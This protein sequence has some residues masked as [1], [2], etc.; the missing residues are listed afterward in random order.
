MAKRT[1]Q[2]KQKLDKVSAAMRM[3]RVVSGTKAVTKAPAKT[4]PGRK[5]PA[6]S[7]ATST[8]KKAPAA[9]KATS[10]AKKAPAAS[11]AT[12]TAKKAPAASKATSTA[13][14]APAKKAPDKTTVNQTNL[15]PKTLGQVLDVAQSQP[16][17]IP[18]QN[19]KPLPLTDLQPEVFEALV[20]EYVT[21]HSR[22]V[23][24]YG[25]S[26]QA[27]Y[28]LDIVQWTDGERPTVFQVK[29]F[30]R[31]R[32]S[33]IRSAVETYASPSDGS[34]RQFNAARFVL[35]T[36]APYENDTK[37][38]NEYHALQEQYAGDL[39]LE[40]WGLEA[41][42]RKIGTY[43][44]LV[45][46][47]IGPEW[48]RAVCGFNPTPEQ[49]AG[50]P[51]LAFV[52]DPI[53]VLS[54]SSLVRSAVEAEDE[55]PAAAANSY[56]LV[57]DGLAARGFPGH[58]SSIREREAAA[59][60]AAGLDT[61]AFDVLYD[62]VIRKVRSG[63]LLMTPQLKALAEVS[64]TEV[65]EAKR[66]VLLQIANWP[67][68]GSKL[69]TTV[70]A[71]RTLAAAQDQTLPE[72]Y[73]YVIE[74]ALVDGL[75]DSEASQLLQE[76]INIADQ[77]PLAEP[78]MRARIDCC[79][80]DARLPIDAGVAAVNTMYET[81]TT[82]A[83]A[84]SYLQAGGFVK[85]RRAYAH[86]M[87]G[88]LAG[89]E[90][91]W[92]RAI[93]DSGE[94]GFYGDTR[95]ALRS[96][97]DV[98]FDHGLLSGP[99]QNIAAA[100]PNRQ[101]LLSIGW[102]PQIDALAAAHEAELPAAFSDARRW[103]WETRLAGSLQL[104]RT[105]LELLGDILAAAKAD[106]RAVAAYIA[107]GA[108]KKVKKFAEST[109]VLDIGYW[110]GTREPRRRAAIVE[111]IATQAQRYPDDLVPFAVEVLLCE[112]RQVWQERPIVGPRPALKAI[113]ALSEFGRR[114]PA[115]AVDDI[116]KIAEPTL[117]RDLVGSDE[118]S[119]LLVEAYIAV[120]TR[121]TD[122]A[123]ALGRMMKQDVVPPPD[124]WSYIDVI[125]ESAR[126][127]LAPLVE[128]SAETGHT[129]AI[130]VAAAWR[131]PIQVLQLQARRACAAL[132]R[133][134]VGANPKMT[135]CGR[136]ELCTVELLVALLA[137]D[138]D[139]LIAVSPRQLVGK[140]QTP[141][142]EAAA[143]ATVPK[144][145][146][147]P[148]G[149]QD[150]PIQTEPDTSALNEESIA[151]GAPAQLA[152][153]V[154]DKL[155]AIAESN[156]EAG[157]DRNS[158]MVALYRLLEHLEP[159]E[160]S[161]LARRIAAIFRDPN[162]SLLDQ[163]AMAMDTPLRRLPIGIRQRHLRATALAASARAYR[164]AR[165]PG[166]E[167][168]SSA[169]DPELVAQVSAGA[170]ELLATEDASDRRDAAICLIDLTES[171]DLS[172]DIIVGLLGDNDEWI[173]AEAVLAYPMSAALTNVLARDPSTLV[174]RNMATLGSG[175]P[176]EVLAV[177]TQDTD[178][179]VAQ[180]ASKP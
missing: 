99:I 10:T 65:Q 38:V 178:P 118:I 129:L 23:Q 144:A 8:A 58:A 161:D 31:L 79:V 169:E 116:L 62:V 179:E 104:E 159:Q 127:E 112:A 70:P 40:V 57:A 176:E 133:R 13:K 143:D 173:R 100:L 1:Q 120:E 47:V 158:A 89:A 41:L 165:R 170:L 71:L 69:S 42:S 3:P 142:S 156:L 64:K 72:L 164:Y 149:L 28:G 140:N 25:R 102:N 87:Q 132:L 39:E 50:P 67:E 22:S 52:A 21:Y 48:A 171:G 37:N 153:H 83:D 74:N 121:R 63:P 19:P 24:F 68:Q 34:E 84:G 108:Y 174:R 53:D 26:G 55:D 105:A 91:W 15:I 45:Y 147:G 27:Q 6:A 130:E 60:K 35:V 43:P 163:F 148:C 59:L 82:A 125:P 17:P 128:E 151:A 5:A 123:M 29:R 11:K 157:P 180:L 93:R 172:T 111:T 175:L 92:T 7:K 75:F 119:R 4:A 166:I 138:D 90:A 124:V 135:T 137:V 109:Q 154:A 61:A 96:L 36:S 103:L 44:Y 131:L 139:N 114:I 162:H 122:V 9:S 97:V 126:A 101:Q 141:A 77:L 76:L 136:A 160:N 113:A 80:A 145:E 51:A 88:D 106:E 86:A 81:I 107:A 85:A 20:A 33:Q 155:I 94:A 134:E 2:Q 167:A 152:A 110:I 115:S 78:Q 18:S 46:R 146:D 30:K 54:L 73:C 56:H 117:D 16:V 168:A 12:S 98:R 177:L 32:P 95:A 49:L 66:S 150:R 14:K